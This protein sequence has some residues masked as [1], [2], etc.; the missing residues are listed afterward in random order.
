MWDINR[1]PPSADLETKAILKRCVSAG[2]ILAELKGA[3]LSIPNQE[4]LVNTLSL[5]EAKDS[6]A[7]ENIITTHDDLYKGDLFPESVGNLAAKEVCNYVQAL[8]TGFSLV[9][10]TGLITNRT[11]LTIQEELERNRAGFRKIPGTNLRND[12]TGELVYTPPQHPEQVLD[13]MS[14]LEIFINSPD[15]DSFDPLVRM[16][17][18]H[19]QFESIHPFH[20]GNGRTGRILNVLYLVKAGLLDIPVLY[21]SRYFIRDKSRY[22]RELQR[23]RDEGHWESWVLYILEAVEETARLTLKKVNDIQRCFNDYKRKIRSGFPKF[24]SLDLINNLFN[25]PYTKIEFIE[26]DL[27]VS[28][29]TATKYL[30]ALSARFLVKQK[31]GRSNYYIN[32]D[33]ITIITAED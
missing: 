26:R 17:L 31:I 9:K 21:L 16:A 22:Y 28:R 30:D 24:Y 27:G 8:K 23:V 32:R 18:L 15:Q 2:R 12:T 19:H 5:Q 33:L 20:D 3:S 1:F 29:L 11:I 4:I 7:I 13:L 10:R 6:S 14:V 25:H